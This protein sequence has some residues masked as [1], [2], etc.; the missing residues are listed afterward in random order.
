VDGNPSQ[1][2]CSRCREL[3]AK[4]DVALKAI[5]VLTTRV[6]DLEAQVKRNS[7]NSSQPPSADPPSVPP[8]P[9]KGPTGNKPG[10]QPG[11]EAHLRRLVDSERVTH[12]RRVLPRHC[13]RCAASFGSDVVPSGEPVR[14]QVVDLPESVAQVTEFELHAVRCLCGKTTR[15]T[16]PPEAP[17]G[18]VGVRLQAFLGLLVGI[19]GTSRRDAHEI[20]TDMLGIDLSLGTISQYEKATSAALEAPCEEVREAI[21]KAPVAHVDETG[22]KQRGKRRWLWAAATSALSYFRI[23]KTRGRDAFE[24]LLGANFDGIVISDRWT[25]YNHLDAR[26]RGLCWAHLKRDFQKLV[27]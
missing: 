13:G 2:G 1:G 21:A 10:G 5:D 22:W 18:C 9:K 14:H 25:A 16:L 20:L 24:S 23:E 19:G 8:R 26:K 3:E 17:T 27:S 6:R 7:R 15:A 11:H 4:L 12:R